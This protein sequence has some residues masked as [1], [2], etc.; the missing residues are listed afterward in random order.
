MTLS[1]PGQ[2]FN[3]ILFP[4]WS[5]VIEQGDPIKQ[6]NE[7]GQALSAA[8]LK[9]LKLIIEGYANNAG[10]IYRN[11]NVSNDRAKAVLNYLIK[12]SGVSTERPGE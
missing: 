11:M 7:T 2:S 3:N 12:N 8:D 10:S 6:L 5:P 9:S 4:P 1:W